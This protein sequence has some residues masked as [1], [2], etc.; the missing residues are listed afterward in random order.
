MLCYYIDVTEN[1][2]EA[3]LRSGVFAGRKLRK[4][5]KLLTLTELR[6]SRPTHRTLERH[7]M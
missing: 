3:Y 5:L 7:A 4:Q 2:T 6:L 1:C